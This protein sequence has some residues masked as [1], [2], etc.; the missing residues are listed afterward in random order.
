M[1]EPLKERVSL[2]LRDLLR[3]IEGDGGTTRWYTP[4]HVERVEA[5]DETWLDSSIEGDKVLVFII[6]D[7]AVDEEGTYTDTDTVQ[8]F[9]VIALK[10]YSPTVTNPLQAGYDSGAEPIRETIQNRLEADIKNQI[11]GDRRLVSS[12]DPEGLALHIEIP[13]T[14]KGPEDTYDPNWAAVFLRVEVRCIHGDTEA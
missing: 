1:P 3:G 4:T 10:R 6:P 5:F 11:R 13:D 9:D 12:D 2:A 7:Q 8:A 14:E